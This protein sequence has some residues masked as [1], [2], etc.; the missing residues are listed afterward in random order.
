MTRMVLLAVL[1]G[2]CSGGAA[3]RRSDGLDVSHYPPEIQQAYQVFAFRCSRCHSLARPLN[4]QV[5]D[6]QHWVEYVARMRRQPGSGI[7]RSNA[8]VI[9]KFLFYYTAHRDSGRLGGARTAAN[10]VRP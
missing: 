10:E 4:A 5:T 1:L 7:S 6:N 2:A 3:Q 9:L 8:R